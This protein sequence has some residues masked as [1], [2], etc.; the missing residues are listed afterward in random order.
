MGVFSVQGLGKFLQQT[1]YPLAEEGDLA[2]LKKVA[3]IFASAGNNAT[4]TL[5]ADMTPNRIDMGYRISGSALR[6]VVS[7]IKIA[8]EEMDNPFN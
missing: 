6:A 3:D 1:V 2:T 8:M 7:A 4:I 5:D